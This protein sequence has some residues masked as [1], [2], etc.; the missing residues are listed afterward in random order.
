MIEDLSLR[1]SSSGRA[2]QSTKPI[3]TYL[4]KQRLHPSKI[5]EK[6]EFC[7]LESYFERKVVCLEHF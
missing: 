6:E 3:A 1:T 5:Q 4:T 7:I 2:S